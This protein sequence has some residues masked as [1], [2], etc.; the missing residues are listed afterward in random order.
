MEKQL[1]KTFVLV[2]MSLMC[3]VFSIL[4]I[5]N[6]LHMQY[7][8]E[9][10]TLQFVRWIT[11]SGILLNDDNSI[12][13]EELIENAYDYD[14]VIALL[15]SNDGEILKKEYLAGSNKQVHLD[16][17][18]KKIIGQDQDEWKI[19]SYIY[20]IK[21][22]SNTQWLVV[23]VDIRDSSNT[24]LRIFSTVLMIGAGII[25]LFLITIYLSRF[26]AKPAEAAM[27]REKQFISDASHELKTPL[28]AISI[29]AQALRVINGENKHINNILS[30]SERMKRLIEKLLT[31]S[32]LEENTVSEKTFFSISSSVEEMVLTY[33]SV[34]YEKGIEYVYSIAENIGFYGVEDE[35]HQLMAIL[36]DN[37][38]RH[39]EA[40]N[41][42]T[43]SLTEQSGRILIT[44]ENTGYGIASE[45]LPHIFDRFYKSDRS[46]SDDSFGLGLAIAKTITKR[47]GGMIDAQS[48]TN[49]KTCFTVS[50]NSPASMRK[51]IGFPD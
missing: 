48:I 38:I 10:D 35:I 32:K 50:F 8:Y 26:I 21:Q 7:W 5:T 2:T 43:I 44:V 34:A 15:V 19:G 33:E 14:S 3:L 17:L 9:R 12:P 40:G 11:Q 23:M 20:D 49:Y 28:G 42:I 16:S 25:V 13:D 31:L 37:A 41:Q 45:D 27:L 51:R 22:I 47:N 36:I 6:Y 39:T 24:S 30:E 4:F 29:N 18:L 46:R 1:R